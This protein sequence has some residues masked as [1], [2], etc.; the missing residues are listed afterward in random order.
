M[1]NAFIRKTSKGV[2]TGYVQVGADFPDGGS[3]TGAYTVATTS[4]ATQTTIIGFS[5]SNVT[6]SAVDVDVALSQSLTSAS[7][8]VSL[9]SSIPLPSGSTV[10]LIGGDQKLVLTTDDLIKVKSSAAG[11]VD[12]V[13]SLL[14]IT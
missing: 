1:A 7:D 5:I 9:G 8:D 6:G 4:P 3:Q 2:G 13:M 14:E 10:V 12:V 11:S